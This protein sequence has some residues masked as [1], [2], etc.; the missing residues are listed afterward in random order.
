M[1]AVLGVRDGSVVD[2]FV[3]LRDSHFLEQFADGL[4]GS[5]SH[6]SHN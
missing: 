1:P 2:Q 6:N 3:G 5:A 4:I